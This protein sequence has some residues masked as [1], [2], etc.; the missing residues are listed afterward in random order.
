MES[1][2]NKKV[3]EV[4]HKGVITVTEGTSVKDI[5][6]IMDKNHISCV[7]VQNK[8][9]EIAGIV[10]NTDIMIIFESECEK[11]DT[12]QQ[13]KAKDLMTTDIITVIQEDNLKHAID[14]LNKD[15]IHR[16]LVLSDGNP[17]GI[18]STS[19]IAREIA[20]TSRKTPEAFYSRF[21]K[22]EK[23]DTSGEKQTWVE[24]RKKKIYDIMTSGVVMVPMTMGVKEVS[25]ILSDKQ[26]HGVVIMT[27]DGEMIGIVS[28]TDIVKAFGEGFEDPLL[29]TQRTLDNLIAGD[30][31]TSPIESIDH[32]RLLEDGTRVMNEKQIHR[33]L[34]LFERPCE[35][36]PPLSF[37]R[38]PIVTQ[39]IVHGVNIPVGILSA[40]DVVRE[41]GNG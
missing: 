9:G 32:C 8:N 5:C 3:E 38:K 41:I 25:K 15:K 4:M 10:S 22:Y 30:I 40:S 37:K 14:I 6:E 12:C 13:I 2:E 18:L 7:V 35:V 20:K 31:M 36:S 39:G 34:V 29:G 1:I 23:L 24:I 21:E 28:D 17:A 16:L 27:D 33:L 19:D 26:I 11:A